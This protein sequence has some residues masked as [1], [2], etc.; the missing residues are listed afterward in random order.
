MGPDGGGDEAR[1][2]VSGQI[3][4]PDIVEQAPTEKTEVAIPASENIG[5]S[6]EAVLS[7]I[8]AIE[9]LTLRSK[10]EQA[11]LDLVKKFNEQNIAD[12]QEEAKD[13]LTGLLRNLPRFAQMVE[14]E[15]RKGDAEDEHLHSRGALIFVDLNKVKQYNDELGYEATSDIIR[16]FA[17]L[18]GQLRQQD[19]TLRYG[20]DEFV[21]FMPGAN[22]TMIG[23]VL[24]K[25]ITKLLEANP[26]VVTG[27]DGRTKQIDV[28]FCVGVTPLPTV[29]DTTD[30]TPEKF[31]E[32]VRRLIT[33]AS[34]LTKIAKKSSSGHTENV[35]AY[36]NDDELVITLGSELFHQE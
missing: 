31:E 20:G 19:V 26:I 3:V 34:E 13:S 2:E 35:A 30:K 1:P 22:P 16:Q 33:E 11:V 28:T 17:L 14:E 29:E 25:R 7:E 27:T 15:R 10:I 32:M 9:D 36:R 24:V 4:E 23:K 18:A 6:V 5:T 21:I 8:S 12:R